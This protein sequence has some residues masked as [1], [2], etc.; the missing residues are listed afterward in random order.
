MTPANLLAVVVLLSTLVLASTRDLRRRDFT[1]HDI[2]PG[3]KI[4][5]TGEYA[6]CLECN[7]CAAIGIENMPACREIS[8]AARQKVLEKWESDYWPMG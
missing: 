5:S 4:G 8:R 1:T 6:C 7:G 2:G 3:C